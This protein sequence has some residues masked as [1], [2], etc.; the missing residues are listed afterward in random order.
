MTTSSRVV[1]QYEFP[2]RFLCEGHKWFTPGNLPFLFKLS[3][4]VKHNSLMD[5]SACGNCQRSDVQSASYSSSLRSREDELIA[6][7]QN[8][9][10]NTVIVLYHTCQDVRTM[11]QS[12]TWQPLTRQQIS[13]ADGERRDKPAL[14]SSDLAV[15]RRRCRTRPRLCRDDIQR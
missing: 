9:R 13:F 8:E 11:K 5:F 4:Y 14:P 10:R 15:K 1:G 6:R 3:H 12:V 2:L 7:T